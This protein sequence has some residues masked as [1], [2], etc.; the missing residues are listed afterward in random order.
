M[1]APARMNP[2]RLY[3]PGA[4]WAPHTVRRDALAPRISLPRTRV[5]ALAALVVTAA[6]LITG[7]SAQ[8]NSLAEQAN[9][10]DDKN[11]IAGDG[12]V[13]EYAAGTR[14]DPVD[15]E[16]MLFDGTTVSSDQW[17]GDV[18]VLNVWYAACAPCR[19]EAP[20][21]QKLSTSFAP[22]GVSFYGINVRDE[23]PTAEAFERN[24]GVTYP[25][26]EDL[27][28]KL[29]LSLTNYVPPQAVPTTLVLDR[30]GRVSA[31]ILGIADESTLRTLIAD[32]LAE[33]AGISPAASTSSE[34]VSGPTN[35]Q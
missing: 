34:T 6:L 27:D 32:V 19:V 23:Q 8:N 11:Y 1:S 10:G 5:S 15:I 20:I 4:P 3:T 21:L 29:L 30:E 18:V 35:V 26:F 25:S 16:G 7:C 24:F 31:R 17:A 22:D 12:S 9:A 28:G 14:S 13:A 33:D 2:N